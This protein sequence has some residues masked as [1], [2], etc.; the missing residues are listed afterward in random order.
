MEG[1]DGR[2]MNLCIDESQQQQMSHGVERVVTA[3]VD[4]EQTADCIAV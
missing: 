1:T 4:D 3:Y 2:R